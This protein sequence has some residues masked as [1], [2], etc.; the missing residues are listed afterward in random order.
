MNALCPSLATPDPHG[1]TPGVNQL[2]LNPASFHFRLFSTP[3]KTFFHTVENPEKKFP[4]RGKS[5]KKV[6]MPWK[7]RKKSFHTVEKPPVFFHLLGH[8]TLDVGYSILDIL[9]RFSGH[10]P[11]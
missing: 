6:S 4:Y 2:R 10:C 8:W 3:W 5:R 11:L 7:I 9:P 1:Y